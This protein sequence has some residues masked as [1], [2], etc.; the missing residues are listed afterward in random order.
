MINEVQIKGFQ[1]LH[2]ITVSLSRFTVIVGPS[3]SGKSA[4]VRALKTLTNNQRG[5]AFISHGMNQASIVAKTDRGTVALFRGKKNEYVLIPEDG[6]Q[7]TF[8]KLAGTTPEEVSDFIGIPSRDPLNYANQF[9]MPYLLT[10]SAA[11]VAR[12]LGE[13]TNVSV[14]FEA[15]R[16]AN[17]RR[18]AA[19]SLL[20]TRAGDYESLTANL[21]KYATLK[22]N[23]A[24]IE[25]AEEY[26][27]S[28]TE[29]QTRITAL[30]NILAD[31][32]SI[33][34][35]VT[36]RTLPD[37]TEVK[38]LDRKRRALQQ[39]LSGY[40]ASDTEHQEQQTLAESRA[41][42]LTALADLKTEALREMGTCPTCGQD[43]SH[44]G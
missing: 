3:S 19:S 11:E 21:E 27:A 34:E 25:R 10:S 6:E 39:I 38:D 29:V 8:T 37:L 4:F 12:T 2:D 26:L 35:E 30:K 5:D 13:L 33:P 18:L 32:A 15:S 24:A 22:D 16:E 20:K 9:D 43:T 17:K 44:A 40:Y 41:L 28:A 1:S 23:L 36:P 42:Q 14:I 31:L 7:K